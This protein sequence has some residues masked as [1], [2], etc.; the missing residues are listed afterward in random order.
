VERPLRDAWRRRWA[1]VVQWVEGRDWDEGAILMAIGAAMGVSAGLG[2]VAFYKLIDGAYF[3]FAKWL[4]GRLEP[5]VHA[6]TLPLITAAGTLAAWAIVRHTKTPEGQ[7]VPDVQRAVAK[8]GGSIP[9][10]PVVIRTI[11]AA[12]TL[13]SGGSAGSEGPVAVLGAATGS[14]LG[15]LFQL[16]SR[17]VKI[18]VGC[19]AAAGI[20]G[21]F[22][23]PFAGAFFALEEVL[24]S[25]SVG[26]FS[27][28]VV[29]SVVGA[30]TVRTFLGTHP[31]FAVPTFGET[32]ALAIVF[33]FPILGIVCGL[34]S[35]LYV[36][37]YFGTAD[38]ARRIPGPPTMVPII[39]GL[40]TGTIVVASR[41]LLVGD[42]HLAIPAEV[43]GGIAWYAL[44][45][46]VL[47]K[48][49]TTSV[50]LGFGGSGGVFTPTLF[51]GAALGGGMGRI[52][53]SLVPSVPLHPERWAMVGMAGLVAGAARAPLTAMFMVFELTD[54]YTIVPPLMLVTVLSLYVSRR[55]AP[56]GLYD[57]WLER[58]GEHLAHGA[59]RRLL[60]RMRTGDAMMKDAPTVD[61]MASLASITAAAARARH[62]A[63]P[64]LEDGRLVGL[65]AYEDIRDVL[66][67]RGELAPLLIA[68]DLAAPVEAVMPSDSLRVALSRMNARAVDA[69]P[70]IESDET[71][72]YVGVLSRADLLL[73]Y[74][75]ELAHEV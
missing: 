55:F 20:A 38:L 21:A 58:R 36:K 74:E 42:G 33:L 25:F 19:G 59:D 24:G 8:R 43:F 7:N 17:W 23:A 52:M 46:L 60:E 16:R 67:D 68:A 64:V 49:V 18:L 73:A 37:T 12:L 9:G 41:G 70:V 50:T 61:I 28:V 47:A 3:V 5:V 65:I 72:R 69:I 10:R 11:A 44:L 71:R 22:N 32:P 63:I 2:V 26:A 57:G 4:G 56:H 48:I 75:Q 34:V 13:G 6:V 1:G 30:V 54:D 14:A 45:L 62:G 35:A 39:G 53:A 66:L 15:R 51:I 27:P 40:I 31:A 29:S